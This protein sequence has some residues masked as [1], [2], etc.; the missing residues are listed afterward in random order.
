VTP[1]KSTGGVNTDARAFA[2]INLT[3]H[4]SGAIVSKAALLDMRPEQIF[5][6]DLAKIY[7]A[8]NKPPTV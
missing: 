6:T 4:V 1:V 2:F 7:L 8:D 3:N 5:N